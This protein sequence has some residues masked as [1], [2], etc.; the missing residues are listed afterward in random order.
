[1]QFS[2]KSKTNFSKLINKILNSFHLSRLPCG[3]AARAGVAR[4]AI[5]VEATGGA[6]IVAVNGG[7]AQSKPAVVVDHHGL[8]VADRPTVSG[9]YWAKKKEGRRLDY[10]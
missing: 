9:L 6:V 10:L 7:G 5:N 2:Q 8:C 4:C 3:A 1:M